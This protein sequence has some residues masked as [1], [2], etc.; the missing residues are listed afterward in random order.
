[1][2]LEEKMALMIDLVSLCPAMG[3]DQELQDFLICPYFQLVYRQ[4][5]KAAAH[6]DP[7][8]VKESICEQFDPDFIQ[9]CFRNLGN[10]IQKCI[11]EDSFGIDLSQFDTNL[12]SI[13]LY[14]C[15]NQDEFRQELQRRT[16]TT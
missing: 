2:I 14:F 6:F 1:M 12:L 9:F 13:A 7:E 4:T 5:N 15:Q 3:L 11:R 10:L 16:E 8:E